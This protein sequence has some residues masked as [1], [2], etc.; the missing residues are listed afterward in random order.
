MRNLIDYTLIN[1]VKWTH[2][3]MYREIQSEDI[4]S[5]QIKKS[6]KSIT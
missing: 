2:E 3:E 6:T 1:Q 4:E 5:K